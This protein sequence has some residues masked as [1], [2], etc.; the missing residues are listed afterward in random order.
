MQC[1]QTRHPFPRTAA[2]AEQYLLPPEGGT[3]WRSLAANA[4]LDAMTLRMQALIAVSRATLP[5]LVARHAG[6]Q[7]LVIGQYVDQLDE[8]AE[9]LDAPLIKGD[10]TVRQREKLYEAFRSGEAGAGRPRVGP[11]RIRAPYPPGQRAEVPAPDRGR[12]RG[13]DQLLVS[14]VDHPRRL[15]EPPPPG[16]GLSGPHRMPGRPRPTRRGD[17]PVPAGRVGGRAGAEEHRAGP[18][19]QLLLQPAPRYARHPRCGGL[20]RF[21]RPIRSPLTSGRPSWRGST[22]GVTGAHP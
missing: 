11:G 1:A 10:T 20:S 2:P 8:L 22:H 14:A 13:G 19:L 18:E 17:R 5:Q 16:N 9:R 12:H 7:T 21:V 3:G 15:G 6:E 4:R